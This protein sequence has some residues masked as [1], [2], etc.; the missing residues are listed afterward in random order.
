[1]F[2]FALFFVV[3]LSCAYV[4]VFILKNTYCMVVI[5]THA[6]MRPGLAVEGIFIIIIVENKQSIYK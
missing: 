1:M 4:N 5:E 6:D 2:D 3:S